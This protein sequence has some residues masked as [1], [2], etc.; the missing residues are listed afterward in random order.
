MYASAINLVNFWTKSTVGI[1]SI[2]IADLFLYVTA[3]A[4]A[5]GL[6]FFGISDLNVNTDAQRYRTWITDARQGTMSWMTKNIEIR[7]NPKLLLPN[8]Q[9]VFSFGFPYFQ[10][11]HWKRPLNDSKPMIAQ[12]ARLRDYHLF[13]RDK[14]LRVQNKL[15]SVC[16]PGTAWRIAVDSAPVLERAFAFK[17]GAGFIGKNTCFIHPQ[18]GSFFLLAELFTTWAVIEEKSEKFS[19]HLTRSPSGGCGSC[20]RCQ[21][22]C[23]TGALD[24]DYRI[25]ASKCIS[26]WTIEHRGLIPLKYWKWVGHYM[27]GC[28]ICQLVC[29]YNRGMTISPQTEPLIR[30]KPGMDLMDIIHMDQDFYEKTFGGTPMTRAKISGLRRNALI[31]AVVKKDPRTHEALE[32]LITDPDDIVK[33]TAHQVT[34]FKKNFRGDLD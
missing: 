26:Y 4:E 17:A 14:I 16:S 24:Q 20:R 7:E 22:H 5:E 11:D 31:A 6:V 30:I 10:G 23:P 2:N 21:V 33:G 9:A 32:R 34:E 19:S 8:A 15:E 18:K 29:P 12:Y 27:F 25:D 28:D 1:N 13:L 3:I